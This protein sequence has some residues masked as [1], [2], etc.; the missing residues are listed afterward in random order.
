[1]RSSE[2]SR[3][4]EPH[5]EIRPLCEKEICR[6]LFLPFSRR[7]EVTRSL[8][9]AGGEWLAAETPFI[10]DWDEKDYVFLVECLRRTVRTGGIVFGAFIGGALKGFAS[11]EAKPFGRAGDYRE[12]TSIHVSEELRGLG[13]GRELFARAKDWAKARKSC[14]F[15][16]IPPR[17]RKH[18]MRLWAASMRRRSTRRTR[19]AS[20]STARSNAVYKRKRRK[21]SINSRRAQRPRKRNAYEHFRRYPRGGFG[22]PRRIRKQ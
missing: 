8:R 7:Q 17:K 14:I 22:D 19:G 4:A 18:F 5:A 3:P 12:L 9:K 6:A 2:N 1:M 20:P 21:N 11:V 15:P 10:D 16:P 13:V